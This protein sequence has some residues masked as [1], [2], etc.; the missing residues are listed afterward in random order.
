MAAP[1]TGHSNTDHLRIMGLVEAAYDFARTVL[2]SDGT[3]VA[4]VFQGGTEQ[5]L[6]AMLKRDFSKVAHAKPKSSRKESSEL[7]LVAS[8]FRG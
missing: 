7:Y 2:A 5:D 4:K 8:G 6:L 1:A 3:F